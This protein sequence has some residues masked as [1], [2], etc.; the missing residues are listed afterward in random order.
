MYPYSKLDP[1]KHI[2]S[3]VPSLELTSHNNCQFLSFFLK[4]SQKVKHS[5]IADQ[6]ESALES[7]KYLQAGMDSDQVEIFEYS[8]IQILCFSYFL[9]TPLLL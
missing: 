6:L 4:F 8:I 1:N 2:H 5:K 7:K 3:A 9:T